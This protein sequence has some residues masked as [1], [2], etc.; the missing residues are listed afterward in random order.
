MTAIAVKRIMEISFAGSD[1]CE[2]ERSGGRICSRDAACGSAMTTTSVGHNYT[3]AAVKLDIDIH[4]AAASYRPSRLKGEPAAVCLPP[5]DTTPA[6][7]AGAYCAILWTPIPPLP[8]EERGS[9]QSHA[10]HEHQ[11]KGQ[12]AEWIVCD[13]ASL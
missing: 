9:A 11:G 12:I 13:P 4:D 1:N 2:K 10:N 8:M 7:A 5:R 3:I 6:S